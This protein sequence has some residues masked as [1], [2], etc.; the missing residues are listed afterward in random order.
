MII[1]SNAFF[2]DTATDARSLKLG[3]GTAAKVEGLEF[4]DLPFDFL[5]LR[6]FRF[7]F[8]SNLGEII[9]KTSI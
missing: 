5:D 7:S 1:A 6:L 9:P 3:L 2:L 4:D 8:L